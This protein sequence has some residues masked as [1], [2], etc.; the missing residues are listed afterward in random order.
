MD[1]DQKKQNFIHPW[2][3]ISFIDYLVHLEPT[4]TPPP[5]IPHSTINT[6]GTLVG[7]II[8]PH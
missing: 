3:V 6:Q 2:F 4:L 8:F 7:L 1:F 5:T